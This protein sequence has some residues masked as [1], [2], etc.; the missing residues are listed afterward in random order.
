MAIATSS[1]SQSPFDFF[2]QPTQDA[3]LLR[4]LSFVPGLKELLM[5]RQVHALEHATVWVLGEAGARISSVDPSQLGGM[6]TEAGFYLYGAVSTSAVQR[7]AHTALQRL[8]SGDWHLAVHPRCGTN[9]SVGMLMTMGL[10]LGAHLLMPKG[11]IEQLLGLGLATTTA[12]HLAPDVGGLVQRYVTTAIP[13]N[14]AIADIQPTRE[15]GHPVHFVRVR[16]V[17]P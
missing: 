8:V 15:N 13:F 16:W 10:A 7:A 3:D 17:E 14:L 2:P 4:Q 9:L 1:V 5:V 12:V 11:P 6:S